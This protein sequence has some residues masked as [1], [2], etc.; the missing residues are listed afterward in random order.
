MMRSP[1]FHPDNVEKED[2]GIE[3]QETEDWKSIYVR[4]GIL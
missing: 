2:K 1:K 3:R 4:I